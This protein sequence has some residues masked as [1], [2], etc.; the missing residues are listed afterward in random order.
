MF[1]CAFYEAKDLFLTASKDGTIKLWN[2]LALNLVSDIIAHTDAVTGMMML[3][4]GFLYHFYVFIWA[5]YETRIPAT[6]H[7][8]LESLRINIG[9]ENKP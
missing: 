3:I 1:S 7:L 5:Q 6:L 4:F 2:G 9:Y 8:W